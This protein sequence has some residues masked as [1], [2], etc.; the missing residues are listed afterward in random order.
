ML[1]LKSQTPPLPPG[2]VWFLFANKKY[3]REKGKNTNRQDAD[4]G[5]NASPRLEEKEKEINL[6]GAVLS[7]TTQRILNV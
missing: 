3:K 1:P 7:T 5:Y 6:K 4:V 2:G